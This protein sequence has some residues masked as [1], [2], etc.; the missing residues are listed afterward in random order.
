MRISPKAEIVVAL[1]IIALAALGMV[2]FV[3]VPQFGALAEQ[4]RQLTEATQDI[5]SAQNLLAQRQSSKV[6]AAQT[7]ADLMRLENQIPDDPQLPTLIIELQNAANEAGLAFVKINPAPVTIGDG[8]N[9]LP[10]GVLLHGRWADCVDYVNR[11]EK[12]DRQL[13]VVSVKLVPLADPSGSVEATNSETDRNP[14]VDLAATI[15]I[16]AYSIGVVAPGTGAVP[17]PPAGGSQ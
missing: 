1:V 16:E 7:Q 15:R 17:L 11:L 14:P 8:Y 2:F 9:A 13:R 3:I 4:D 10:I 5:Q 12:L 6:R